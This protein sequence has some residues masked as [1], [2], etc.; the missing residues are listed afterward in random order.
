MTHDSY[1][2]RIAIFGSTGSIGMQALDVIK[3][4]L[5]NFLL[6]FLLRTKITILLV[7]AGI[8]I[9]SKHCSVIVDETKYAEV[10]DAL[11]ST[12]IKVFAGEKVIGG[13]RSYG[14]L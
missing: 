10:K 9:Q 13:S 2:K 6:R 8:T 12:D 5:I 14:L 7:R 4:I 3:L 1:I 11:A